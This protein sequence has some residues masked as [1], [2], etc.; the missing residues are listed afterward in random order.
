MTS[1]SSQVRRAKA[2]F[3]KPWLSHG[4]QLQL[5]RSRGLVIT[6]EITAEQF[7]SHVNYYRFSG[8]CL[9]FETS[10]H[11]FAEGV[12][13]EQI[14]FAYDFD[15]TLRD[16]LTEA[17]EVCEIDFRTAIA[18]AIAENLGPFGHTEAVNFSKKFDHAEWIRRIQDEAKRS[19]EVFV[20]HFKNNYNEFPDLP[21]W[22]VTEILS[23]GSLSWMFHWLLRE[24]QRT[25]AAKYG[26]Q[27]AVL[28]SWMHHL[29][30]IRNLCAHHSRIWGRVWQVKPMLPAGKKWQVPLLPSNNRLFATLLLLR[31]LMS[32]IPA[33]GGFA[34]EWKTR[35][36]S[37]VANPPETPLA[38][39][40]MGLSDRWTDH[41]TWSD[42]VSPPRQPR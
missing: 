15:L 37:R 22:T 32:H 39:E 41:P 20:D 5:L 35:V 30:Y 29:V 25:V 34:S 38:L 4:D 26:L 13:F 12:T 19:S 7:L 6:D 9:G 10:R 33:I 36:E 31:H 8:Y 40:W 14:A 24:H 28:A 42:Q 21:V 17:L 11:V 23:F 16:L 18:V 1:V 27:P 3:A 2:C